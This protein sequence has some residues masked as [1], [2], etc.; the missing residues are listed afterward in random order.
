MEVTLTCF[1]LDS[2]SESSNE[3]ASKH[4]IQLIPLEVFKQLLSDVPCTTLALSDLKN[5]F[6]ETKHLWMLMHELP[7]LSTEFVYA[8]TI[9]YRENSNQW[10]GDTTF[11]PS[12]NNGCD[13]RRAR[14]INIVFHPFHCV[15]A[16]VMADYKSFSFSVNKFKGSKAKDTGFIIHHHVLNNA[17]CKHLDVSWSPDGLYLLALETYDAGSK[18]IVFYLND[19]HP[20]KMS[21]L[22][23]NPI[24][25]DRNCQSVQ[26][27]IDNSSFFFIPDSTNLAVYT[28]T[29][30][31]RKIQVTT[32][33][34]TFPI[35]LLTNVTRVGGGRRMVFI[36]RQ[37]IHYLKGAHERILMFKLDKAKMLEPFLCVDFAGLLLDASYDWLSQIIII[38]HFRNF[39]EGKKQWIGKKHFVIS[40]N[41]QEIPFCSFDFDPEQPSPETLEENPIQFLDDPPAAPRPP[42]NAFQSK[43]HEIIVTEL[44]T[45]PVESLLESRPEEGGYLIRSRLMRKQCIQLLKTIKSQS[46]K[47]RSTH[48]F[49]SSIT[50]HL[51]ILSNYEMFH[52]FIIFKAPNAALSSS[53]VNFG[54]YARHPRKPFY[55]KKHSWSSSDNAFDIGLVLHADPATQKA[56]PPSSTKS[57]YYK[58]KKAVFYT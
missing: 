15:V 5:K 52:T 51:I 45:T 2:I 9:G 58:N 16:F 55:I 43:W 50:E 39:Q 35:R 14:C 3:P 17:L 53:R 24:I 8:T 47:A 13:G 22:N 49:I 18:I 37:C 40:W 54:P 31:N 38:A 10:I 41:P 6:T 28:L 11:V 12:I 23:L 27:W 29:E 4:F 57:S 46:L 30:H 34:H 33:R 32:K 25:V 48:N 7:L 44:S 26:C 56:F 19:T 42:K 36:G 21:E 1:V 20:Y